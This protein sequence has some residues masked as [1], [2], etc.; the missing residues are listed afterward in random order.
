MT[1]IK[2]KTI[3]ARSTQYLRD[4]CN[5]AMPSILDELG[6][7]A[8]FGNATMM[9]DG[10]SV[11][12]KVEV[13]LEGQLSQKDKEK[14]QSL[15]IWLNR[16]PDVDLQKIGEDHQGQW[17]LVGVNYRSP[18][19][20]ILCMKM[21]SGVTYKFTEEQAKEMFQRETENV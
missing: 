10:S 15:D 19:Y 2:I 21:G 3:N 11:T 18:K 6:V 8:E 4:V 12:F 9:R 16:N 5:K 1:S 17:S 20:P 13:K 14:K 7:Q